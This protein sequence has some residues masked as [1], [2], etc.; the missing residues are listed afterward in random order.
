VILVG[1]STRVPLVRAYVKE[2]FGKE[3]L[4]DIDPDQ[5]VA[6][7]AALQADLLA[8]ESPEHDALILDVIPL[9]LG[10][11]T[12]GGVAEKILPRNT[13]IPAGRAQQFTTYADNGRRASS[14]TWCRAS[15]S[16]RRQP[17]ARAGHSQGHS[18]DARGRGAWR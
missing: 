9:S 4:A 1:G 5:V 14:C 16:W 6:Y 13:T 11:E 2:L 8:G 3:P 12:M 18:A 15:G 17:L 10:I 7:G